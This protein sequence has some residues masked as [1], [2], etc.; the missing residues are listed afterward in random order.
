MEC[1]AALL[2][3]DPY[4]LGQKLVSRVLEGKW[5]RQAEN[6][7]M[8]LGLEQSLY[9]RDALSKALYARLFDFLVQVRPNEP[10]SH[11]VRRD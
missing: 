9:T 7:E 4:L 6:V 5:G 10:F 2:E 11:D 8:T 1:P 3:I